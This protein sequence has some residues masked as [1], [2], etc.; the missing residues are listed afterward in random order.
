MVFFIC[1]LQS[2][3]SSYES[4][5]ISSAIQYIDSAKKIIEN[6]KLSSLSSDYIEISNWNIVKLKKS[7][8]MG[9]KVKIRAKLGSINTDNTVGIMDV[10][11]FNT[12]EDSLI[13]TLLSLTPYQTYT[14]YG[15]VKRYSEYS[16]AP[17][18]HIEA[19]E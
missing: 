10:F 8:Y 5:D 14:F 4:G 19:I 16:D 6:E 11:S 15:T 13:D 1:P 3:Q 12:F 7:E 18:L 9:K 2:A 17:K